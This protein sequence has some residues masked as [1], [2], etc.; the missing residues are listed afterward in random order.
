VST[1]RSSSV[2]VGCGGGV[3]LYGGSNIAVVVVIV[4][5]F[6]ISLRRLFMSV[7]LGAVMGGLGFGLTILV[8]TTFGMSCGA[9]GITTVD[10]NFGAS[11][12]DD[13]DVDDGLDDEDADV[14]LADDDDD[15]GLE[16]DD[17]DV[18]LDDDDVDVGLDDVDVGRVLE[19]AIVADDEARG[20]LEFPF[21]IVVSGRFSI[22][23]TLSGIFDGVVILLTLFVT[24][25]P[26]VIVSI[27]LLLLLR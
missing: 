26:T 14:G 15:V 20:I 5:G 11:L 24:V 23:T 16:D 6:A 13:D 8:L 4:E 7:G 2:D 9:C 21:V 27:L 17:V 25:S 3:A 12:D 1:L 10:F 22:S 19:V 18:G